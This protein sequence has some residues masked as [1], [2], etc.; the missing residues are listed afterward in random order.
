MKMESVVK[1]SVIRKKHRTNTGL[2]IT[3]KFELTVQAI[4][5]V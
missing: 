1:N 5:K 4:L 3:A 2:L